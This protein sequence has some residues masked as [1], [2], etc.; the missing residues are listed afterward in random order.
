[1]VSIERLWNAAALGGVVSAILVSAGVINL[2]DLP[3]LP[4]FGMAS[5]GSGV[6]E[7]PADAAR[8]AFAQA[9]LAQSPVPA[10][11]P[12]PKVDPGAGPAPLQATLT[13]PDGP[14]PPLRAHDEIKAVL[15]TTADAY[16]YCYY[17]DGTGSISRIFPNRFQPSAL[18]R[19]G[20]LELPGSTDAFALVADVPDR[21]EEV[22]CI[23]APTDLGTKL[24][25]VLQA[26]DLAPLTVASLDEISG[27][28]QGLGAQVVETRLVA[29]IL[30]EQLR[31]VPSATL[32]AAT[33]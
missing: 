23:A 19:S 8:V 4:S 25:A 28:F 33:Y 15:M 22:R 20:S 2:G 3:S 30:P 11:T 10:E 27:M 32:A 7:A 5:T 26:E 1:M 24:P 18:V 16:A 9:S 17:A 12:A 14:N 6:A 29:Q 13:T 31:S 21:T